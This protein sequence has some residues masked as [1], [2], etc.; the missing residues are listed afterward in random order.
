MAFPV[1]A[2]IAG[3]AQVMGVGGGL[4]SSAMNIHE[5][6]QAR[7]FNKWQMENAHQIEV[8][9]LKQA[10]LNPILS[11]TGGSGASTS[12]PAP[13]QVQNPM[14]SLSAKQLLAAQVENAKATTQNTLADTDSKTLSNHMNQEMYETDLLRR[15]LEY[16]NAIKDYDLKGA[17]LQTA[18]KGLLRID[19]ELKNMELQRQHSALRINEAKADSAYY[20]G[21]VGKNERY[22]NEGSRILGNVLGGL[23]GAKG[24][25]SRGRAGHDPHE[26][27]VHS[28]K[29]VYD[30]RGNL[31][32]RVETKTSRRQRPL[33]DWN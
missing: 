30:K 6:R 24:R 18:Q 20:G 13:G 10:G 21:F 33:P 26:Y 8:N 28:A 5:A 12:A 29:D 2:A 1:A 9:D 27:D 3:G 17:A 14:E 16:Q 22:L 25:A 11:A 32:S 31:S 4:V 7:R 19:A 15:R 23:Q